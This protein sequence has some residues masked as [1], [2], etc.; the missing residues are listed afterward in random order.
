MKYTINGYSQT[1]LL[2]Y[3]LDGHDALLLRAIADIYSS[4]SGKLDFITHENDRYIWLTYKY[5]FNELPVLGTER[6]V[7]NKINS[8]VEKK[9]LK[10]IVLNVKNGVSGKY[11]FLTFGE[12]YQDLLE[13]DIEEQEESVSNMKNFQ[14]GNEKTSG[15]V[16]KNFHIKDPSI[17]NPSII[18][19]N[20]KKE[21]DTL[22]VSDILKKYR[23][24]NLPK[25]EYRPDNRRIMDCY[26]ILGPSLFKALEIMSRIDYVKTRF[27][28]NMIFNI[29]NLKK[30]LNGTFKNIEEHTKIPKTSVNFQNDKVYDRNE[31]YENMMKLLGFSD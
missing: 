30:A 23:E 15:G 14:E 1:Q 22:L 7:I 27:S 25:Y 24:L 31:E 17:I 18:I 10:K 26:H 29:E 16:M 3:N 9:I 19:K 5:L 13:Y 8:L 11:M 12:N 20:Q 2:K 6:T 21:G 4:C 28:I